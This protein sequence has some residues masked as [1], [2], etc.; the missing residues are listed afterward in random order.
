MTGEAPSAPSPSSIPSTSPR[1]TAH[2]TGWCEAASPNGQRSATTECEPSVDL[3]ARG[4]AVRGERRGDRGHRALRTERW[5]SVGAVLLAAS[6]TAVGLADLERHRL[7]ALGPEQLQ[8]ALEEGDEQLVGCA[9][10]PRRRSE[11]S[12]AAY[13]FAGRPTPRGVVV[14]ATCPAATSR[15]RWWRA[16]FGWIECARGDV[17]DRRARVR[18]HVEEDRPARRVAEGARQRRDDGA[19]RGGIVGHRRRGDALHRHARGHRQ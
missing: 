10:S 16:T 9:S 7:G 3:G 14:A 8:G 17:A 11:P 15:S 1:S 12:V 19:E 4:E 6:R 18:A 13:A 5:A 2:S